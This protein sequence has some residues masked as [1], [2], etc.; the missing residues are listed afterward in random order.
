VLHSELCTANVRMA[1]N[2]RVS[3][4]RDGDARVR[5]VSCNVSPFWTLLLSIDGS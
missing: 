3:V 4:A 5:I 1:H 2:N